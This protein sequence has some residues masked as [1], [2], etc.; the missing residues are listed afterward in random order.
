[1][2]NDHAIKAELE[3]VGRN[4]VSKTPSWQEEMSTHET[5]YK[6]WMKPTRRKNEAPRIWREHFIVNTGQYY[7]YEI[8]KYFEE[9][10]K[11][12]MLFTVNYTDNVN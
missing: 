3:P 6:K 4:G 11:K 5:V 9:K 7:C 1:M 8:M 12:E 10:S 2:P